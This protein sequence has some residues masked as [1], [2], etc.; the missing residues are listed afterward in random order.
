MSPPPDK[1]FPEVF[2]RTNST[3]K[4]W[5]QEIIPRSFLSFSIRI[6][7][8]ADSF[9]TLDKT[10]ILESADSCYKSSIVSHS[11]KLGYDIHIL[12]GTLDFYRISLAPKIALE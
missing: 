1:V 2:G 11:G 9:P 4:Y 12:I 7:S 10:T 8:V 3:V 5:C 6:Q